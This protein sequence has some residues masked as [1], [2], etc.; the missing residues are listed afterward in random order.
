[1]TKIYTYAEKQGNR[2]FV[3]EAWRDGDVVVNAPRVIDEYPFELFLP[4]SDGREPDSLSIYRQGLSRLQ[5]E[6]VK[7]MV[8]FVDHH[9]GLEI[10]G[11]EDPLAQWL[12]RE[13]PVAPHVDMGLLSILNIDIE[14][15]H[16][17]G[18]PS[19]LY[20]AQEILSIT[21]KWFGK[22]SITLGLKPLDRPGYFHCPNEVAMLETFLDFYERNYPDV[23]TGWNVELFDITY[24]VNRMRSI[25]GPK[26]PARLSPFASKSRQPISDRTDYRGEPYYKILGVTVVDYLE[27]YKKFSPDKQ[28]SYRLG[29]IGEVELGETKVDYS[30]YGNSLM[31]LYHENF[32]LFIEYNEVDAILVE[33]LDVKLQFL[34]LL[35]TITY[36]VRGRVEDSQATVKPW[37]TLL[38]NMLLPLGMQPPPHPRP[39]NQNIVGGFVKEP[40]PGLKRWVVTLDLASLYPNIARTLNM[41]PE[42][43]VF[44]GQ[45]CIDEILAGNAPTPMEGCAMAANGSQYRQD[46]VG[47]IPMAMG[48]LLDQRNVEKGN[49]KD[50]KKK[51]EAA[52]AAGDEQAASIRDAN[53]SRLNAVQLA[54]KTLANGGYGAIA[55][56]HFRYFDVDIAE[57]IT[58][59]G[60]T[61]IQFIAAA[62]SAKMDELMGTSGVDYVIGSDTDSC[63]TS[64]APFMDAYIEACGMPD[65]YEELIDVADAF[66]K[67][68]LEEEVLVPKFAELSAL[69]GS[70]KSTLSMKREAIADRGLFRAKKNYVLQVW[71]NEGVRYAEPEMKMVGIE[72]ARTTT[73]K[74]CRDMLEEA[75]K[76]ILNGDEAQLNARFKEWKDQFMA[77]PPEAIAFPRGVSEIKK[78]TGEDGRAILKTPVQTKA[79]MCYNMML[80]NAG[81]MEREPI[82]EGSKLKFVYLKHG[83]P[84][85]YN[86]IGFIDDLPAP[87]GLNDWIDR[88]DQFEKALETPLRSFTSLVNWTVG[89]KRASLDLAFFTE[90]APSSVEIARPAGSPPPVK[91]VKPRNS[92]P[93]T[94]TP[95]K[96]RKAVKPTLDSLF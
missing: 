78:W 20:A 33:K 34:Q 13:Y 70:K 66:V 59:T 25:L 92:G 58:M 53:V 88:K 31:R 2:L 52:K 65:R 43:I 64:I 9:D 83:N 93:R 73:P 72:T 41:S 22:P 50:E 5:F 1:M 56:K 15:E 28:E 82:T 60:Q 57:G 29:H 94:S 17:Q 77:A 76:I 8:E 81:L 85:G 91:T 11:M 75:L 30:A 80:K 21:M 23:I 40:E 62:I 47:I 6:D 84:T 4:S 63:M 87:F 14:V 86:V 71:D 39:S 35:F 37:D 3:R 69:L 36:L 24:L 46:I 18:F 32:P 90:E 48:F 12:A 68:N 51:K 79:A 96:V 26:A 19:A 45:P 27:L 95:V 38:Y 44:R 42:T 49:M 7:S 74:M 54:L 61:V 16:S 55:N 89:P 67:K 10:H